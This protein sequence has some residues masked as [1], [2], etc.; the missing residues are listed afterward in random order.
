MEMKGFIKITGVGAYIPSEKVLSDDL[1]RESS[2]EQ[3]GIPYEYLRRFSGIEE[4]RFANSRETPSMM[5]AEASRQALRNANI[6]ISDIDQIIFCGIDR[7][8]S[9]PAMAHMI[10][11]QLEI[12][13]NRT[14]SLD[15]SDA[16]HG[17]ASGMIHAN[18]IIGT[19]AAENILLCTGENPSLI[20]KAVVQQ[21]KKCK[22]KKQFKDLMGALTVGDSGG[23]LIISKK[24]KKSEGVQ[25]MHFSNN[26]NLADYCYYAHKGEDV[27]FCMKMS[28]ISS[29]AVDMHR[30]MIDRTY[31]LH[32][33]TPDMISKIYCHQTGAKPQERLAEVAKVDLTQAPSTYQEYGNLTSATIPINMHLHPPETGE[34]YFIFSA[35][36]GINC[37]QIGVQN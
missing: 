25:W 14:I 29:A 36:S 9:E 33:W 28:K 30:Q 32:R 35:G 37:G 18:G 6:S 21:L 12:S 11:K 27:E 4:R 1:M 26:S 13:D 10:A 5:A 16:C 22:N 7:E 15:I 17:I 2:S 8:K 3:F 34:K 31:A 20:C 23:A 24:Q 19:G